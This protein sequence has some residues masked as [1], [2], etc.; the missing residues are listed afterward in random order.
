MAA[1]SS[2][3]LTQPEAFGLLAAYTLVYVLPLYA[4]PQTRASPGRSRDAPEAIRAR[5]F[6][7]SLSTTA[8]SLAT[9]LLL[10]HVCDS[11]AGTAATSCSPLHLMGYWPI[12]LTEALKSCLLTALLFAAPLYESL[13][14]DG[15]WREWVSGFQPLRDIWAEWPAWRNLVAG[16]VTEECLFRS[17]AIPL[18]L[19][20][21]SSLSRI[22]FLSPVVFGLAHL[23]HFYEFRVTHPQ[24]PLVAAV[25]RSVLQFSYTSIFGA[26]ANF[27]FLRTGSLLAVVA[28][29]AFCNSMGLPRIWGAVQPYWLPEAD[30]ARPGRVVLWSGI[31]YVLLIGGSVAW[32]K[33]LY[34]LTES[35]IALA[36]F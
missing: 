31:Y 10:P 34:F 26:Y 29:H 9:L 17:A 21:G 14:I 22:I 23:H 24:T 3:A 1:P 12:G 7:V 11:A 13:V 8:C 36:A 5:I 19:V 27:L 32:W 6:A 33:N 2:G 30:A 25:A 15:G 16:P 18:L 20:A 35:P 4:S 28:V